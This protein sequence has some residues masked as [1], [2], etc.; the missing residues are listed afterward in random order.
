MT[1]DK[2][3]FNFLE[4]KEGAKVSFGGNQSGRITGIGQVSPVKEVYLVDGLC[5][6]L[7]SVS[8]CTDRGNWVIFDSNECL[9]VGK[10]KLNLDKSNLSC[11]LKANRN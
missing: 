7:L 3:K 1:G 4:I 10:Q 8:Q 2:E 6:N 11:K 5:H 9:V